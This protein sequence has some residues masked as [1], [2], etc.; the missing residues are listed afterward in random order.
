[1]KSFLNSLVTVLPHLLSSSLPA[2][3]TLYNCLFDTCLFSRQNPFKVGTISVSPALTHQY[4]LQPAWVCRRDRWGDALIPCS[5]GSAL[6]LRQFWQGKVH[7]IFPCSLSLI[8]ICVPLHCHCY[9]PSSL[10]SSGVWTASSLL[11]SLFA[12]SLLQFILY[13]ASEWGFNKKYLFMAV[14]ERGKSKLVWALWP[15]VASSAPVLL[16]PVSLPNISPHCYP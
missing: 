6:T 1:M 11:T 13:T 8:S 5:Q 14:L 3:I 9:H 2:A 15:L 4:M 10:L 7:Y 16:C 12:Q